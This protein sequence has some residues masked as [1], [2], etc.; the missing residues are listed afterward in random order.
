M[1]LY[2]SVYL[3]MCT[4]GTQ[5]LVPTGL[6]MEIRDHCRLIKH[7]SCESETRALSTFS[8]LDIIEILAKERPT[9]ESLLSVSNVYCC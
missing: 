9:F 6:T 3:P 4:S 5:I 7:K 2:I 1:I 8:T